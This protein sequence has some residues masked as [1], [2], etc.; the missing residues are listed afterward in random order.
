MKLLNDF[1]YGFINCFKGFQV[2][3]EK[4]LWH[5]LFYPLLL[6]SLL[7]IASIY[8]IFSFADYVSTKISNAIDFESI[9]S[10]VS[11]LAFIK[12][13]LSGIFGFIVRWTIKIIF[14]FIGSVFTKYILLILLSPVFSLLSE[15]ADEKL[16]GNTFPFNI[17][18]LLKDVVRGTIVNIRNML[19]ELLIGFGLWLIT[20]FFPPLFI[21]TFP[22]GL[23]IG[24]YFIGFSLL[25][26]SCERHKYSIGSGVQ[27]IKQNK[28]YAI[29]I[30][31]VYAMFMSLPTIAGDVIGIMLGPTLAVVGATI[32]F[33]EI[34]KRLKA[35]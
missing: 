25:D 30:G 35:R 21:I 8:G 11:W 13:K 28:G 18:Q 17:I 19:L 34:Q 6:W 32:S 5:F 27:F 23:L 22:L 1:G 33:L 24:W 10:D 7:W 12:P 20:L 26:Y 14:W 4:G 29:G 31:C 3:F 2:L 15:L 9:G 16:T